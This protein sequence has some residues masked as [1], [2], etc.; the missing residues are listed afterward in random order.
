[1]LVLSR[2]ADE[3][4]VLPECGVT[5]RVLDIGKRKVRLGIT[6]P[7]G[8]AVHRVEVWQRMC[9]QQEERAETEEAIIGPAAAREN[10]RGT[11]APAADVGDLDIALADWI[12]RKTGGATPSLSVEVTGDRIVMSGSAG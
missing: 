5:I 4:I 9:H 8:T 11:C 2:K 12:T 7:G 1:M 6:A 10:G 3:Q